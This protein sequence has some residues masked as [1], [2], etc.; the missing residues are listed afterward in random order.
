MSEV[1]VL[2]GFIFAVLTF[3]FF[4]ATRYQKEVLRT[5]GKVAP[6]HRLYA[7]MFGSFLLP[8]GLFVSAPD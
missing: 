5:N 3:G 8:I 1:N 2:P 4:D 7:A 6:E